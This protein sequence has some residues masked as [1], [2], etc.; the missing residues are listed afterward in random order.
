MRIV[1]QSQR[2]AEG[3]I[4]LDREG[5]PIK[6]IPVKLSPGVN[7]ITTTLR[8]DKPGVQRIRAVL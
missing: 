2:H 1:V 4:V 3:T 7:L 5:A 6:R 8:A